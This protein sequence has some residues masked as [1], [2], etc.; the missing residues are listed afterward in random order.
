M[1][2]FASRLISRT[3]SGAFSHSLPLQFHWVARH[4]KMCKDQGR[5]SRDAFLL[6]S[7]GQDLERDLHSQIAGYG[8]MLW[9]RILRSTL[10]AWVIWL[11]SSCPKP[12]LATRSPL[13]GS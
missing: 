7:L 5:Q 6:M 1:H 2:F 9:H 11:T 10:H 4:A 13:L 12:D 8:K 3:A